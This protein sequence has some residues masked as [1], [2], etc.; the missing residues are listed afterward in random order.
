MLRG[1]FKTARYVVDD[2]LFEVVIFSLSC[3]F[4]PFRKEKIVPDAASDECLLYTC[5]IADFP[6]KMGKAAVICFKIRT[7]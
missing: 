7:N 5:D 3:S 2:Q 1:H 6:V 4:I